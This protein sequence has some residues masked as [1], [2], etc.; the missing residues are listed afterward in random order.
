MKNDDKINQVYENLNK[1]SIAS[2]SLYDHK[3]RKSIS[4]VEFTRN[5]KKPSTVTT[6][7]KAIKQ[8]CK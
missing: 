6:P 7:K 1:K 5:M 3:T 8:S 2:A 4:E